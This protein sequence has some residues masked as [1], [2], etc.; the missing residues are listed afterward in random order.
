MA[1][2]RKQIDEKQIEQL[3]AIGCTLTEMAAVLDCHADTLRDRFSSSIEKGRSVGKSSLKRAQWDVGVNKRN[4]AMLIWLG[5][6]HLG[7][8]DSRQID[9]NTLT[10]AQA[11]SILEEA[12]RGDSGEGDA[13]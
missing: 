3:A 10:P 4:V 8:R 9:L 6:Q 1:R 13:E 12:D 11:L 7:Q 5:K 2:P